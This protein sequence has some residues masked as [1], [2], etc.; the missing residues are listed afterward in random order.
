M[1][2]MVPSDLPVADVLARISGPR[3]EEAFRLLTLHAEVSGE[4]PVVWA[5]RIVGFGEYHYRYASGHEGDAPRL[6]FAS[7]DRR[8]TVYLREDFASLD[9]D[10][11]AA[12]GPHTASKVCLYLKRLEGVD[13]EVLRSLL[14]RTLADTPS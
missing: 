10:L 1:P 6:A 12:L 8:H 5:D 14:E 3:R 4:S 11:L 2:A 7:D 13:E 9:A